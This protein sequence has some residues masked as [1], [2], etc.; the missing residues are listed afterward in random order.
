LLGRMRAVATPPMMTFNTC[1]RS[2][3]ILLIADPRWPSIPPWIGNLFHLWVAGP[4]TTRTPCLGSTGIVAEWLRKGYTVRK[5]RARC[6]AGEVDTCLSDLTQGGELAPCE[7]E[8]RR[9]RAKRKGL[10]SLLPVRW[11]PLRCHA[12]GTASPPSPSTGRYGWQRERE[13]PPCQQDRG[14]G[15]AARVGDDAPFWRPP[16]QALTWHWGAEN[17]RMGKALRLDP[18]GRSRAGIA[19][20]GSLAA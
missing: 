3:C 1:R 11:H 14:C 7:S 17:S 2:W 15:G 9:R 5:L 13:Q 6:V 18:D 19:C 20:A 16:V 8:I 4:P 12:V 10:R